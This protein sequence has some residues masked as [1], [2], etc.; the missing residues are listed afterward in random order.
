M[1]KIINLEKMVDVC[2]GDLKLLNINREIKHYRR[3]YDS[4]RVVIDIIDE[5]AKI[6]IPLKNFKK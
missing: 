1:K 2:A 3:L 5:Y 6:Y 4:N